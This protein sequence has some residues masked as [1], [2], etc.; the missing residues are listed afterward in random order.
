MALVP[1]DSPE[2]EASEHARL[3]D[4]HAH[5]IH[6]YCFRRTADAALAEDLTSIVFLEAWRRRREVTQ[7]DLPWLYGVAT[8]VLRNQR[9]S[10]RRHQAALLRLPRPLDEP[11][12]ADGVTDRLDDESRMRAV[13]QAVRRLSRLEQEIVSLCIW[14]GLEPSEAARALGVAEATVRTRLHRGRRHLQ[15]LSGAKG[16]QQ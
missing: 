5:A 1:V 10:Q 13:L 12:F 15:A 2:T 4:A 14:E 3:W 16:E 11:D 9:R 7:A 8:N 6:R